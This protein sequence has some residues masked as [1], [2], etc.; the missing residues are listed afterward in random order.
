MAD[1][2]TILD[3]PS[4]LFV[5][6]YLDKFAPG[7]P[8]RSLLT[9][10]AYGTW[11]DYRMIESTLPANL[12]LQPNSNAFNKLKKLT[13]LST[14]SEMDVVSY[15]ILMQRIETTN[16]VDLETLVID[17]IANDFLDAKIDEQNKRVVCTRCSARC[18]KNEPEA[19]LAQVQNIQ[20]IRANIA[21]ALAVSSS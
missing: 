10:F 21:S 8:E 2:A 15:E 4:I 19:I 5:D 17:L 18:V 20:K 13:L 16:F 11:V 9:I 12:K 7:S 14:F 3:D 6:S 1:I